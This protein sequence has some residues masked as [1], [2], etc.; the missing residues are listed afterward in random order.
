M[1][2]VLDFLETLDYKL[3]YDSA[4]KRLNIEIKPKGVVST[5]TPETAEPTGTATPDPHAQESSG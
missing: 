4:T 5:T 2:D 1:N 3:E